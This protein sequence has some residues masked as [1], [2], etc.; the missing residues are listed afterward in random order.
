MDRSIEKKLIRQ[1][2]RQNRSERYWRHLQQGNIDA[3]KK[4]H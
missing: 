4:A 1:H 3:C 2:E